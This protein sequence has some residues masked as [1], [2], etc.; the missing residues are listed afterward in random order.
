MR[1]TSF[2][3][4]DSLHLAE[5]S[6]YLD[7]LGKLRSRGKNVGWVVEEEFNNLWYDAVHEQ[8]IK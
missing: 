6:S 8:Q 4:G 3:P 7:R 1:A 2:A 5:R